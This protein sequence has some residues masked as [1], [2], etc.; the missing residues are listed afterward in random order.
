MPRKC[1]IPA[2]CFFFSAD[3]TVYLLLTRVVD[4]VLVAREVVRPRKDG[5]AWLSR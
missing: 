2:K 5:V 1:I 3:G 4:R